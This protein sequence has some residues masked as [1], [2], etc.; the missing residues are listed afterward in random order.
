[1]PIYIFLCLE[2]ARDHYRERHKYEVIGGII[3][4]VHDG[5]NKSGLVAA[6]HRCAMLQISLRTSDWIRLSDWEC[7]QQSEWTRTKTSLQYHQNYINS[8]LNDVDTIENDNLPEWIPTNIKDY[9]GENVH[10][11]LLCG[12]DLLESFAVPGLWL[13][14]DVTHL[15]EQKYFVL[16]NFIQFFR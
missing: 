14:E 15:T 11:K 4:P 6:K 1:M 9:E 12:A 13:E 16:T 7:N 5:Y 2:I 8:V 3:S 10:V